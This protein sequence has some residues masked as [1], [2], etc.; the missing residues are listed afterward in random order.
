MRSAICL[1][2]GF[3]VGAAVETAWSQQREII[4]LNHVAIAVPDFDGASRFYAEGMGFPQAFAFKEANGSPNLSY[5]QVNRNTF[6]EL[7]PVTPERPAGFVHF[8]L[9]VTQL[10]GL[11]NRLRAAGMEVRDPV[12]SP[13]TRSRIA[14][15]RTPQGTGVELLE[16]GPDSLHQKVMEGSRRVAGRL[17]ARG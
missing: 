7:M 2:V 9:E 5:F 3:A 15:A 1:V 8:G 14:I 10:D 13:R 17:S 12:V 6:I 16:F 4:S 11:V